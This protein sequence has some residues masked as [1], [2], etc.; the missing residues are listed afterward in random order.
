M[1]NCLLD[2]LKFEKEG[3]EGLKGVIE[4]VDLSVVLFKV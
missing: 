1:K 3:M 2:L 4:N